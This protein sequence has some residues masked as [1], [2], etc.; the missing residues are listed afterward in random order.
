MCITSYYKSSYNG[1]HH[2]P[3]NYYLFPMKLSGC[4]RDASILK[5]F[6]DFINFL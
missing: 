3:W 6:A 4:F 2:N 5:N 1:I